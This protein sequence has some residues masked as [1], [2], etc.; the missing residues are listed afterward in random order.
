[1]SSITIHNE[2]ITSNNDLRLISN[3]GN[4]YFD[5]YLFPKTGDI[6]D[7][8]KISSNNELAWDKS[9]ITINENYLHIGSN[10][11][12][13]HDF[14][15]GHQNTSLI[16][17]DFDNGTLSINTT[18]FIMNS[19]STVQLYSDQTILLSSTNDQ[20]V[21]HAN[22]TSINGIEIANTSGGVLLEA[23]TN[24]ITG[25]LQISDKLLQS[26]HI[27]I[28]TNTNIYS[29]T[30]RVDSGTISSLTDLNLNA[31]AGNNIKLGEVS[32]PNT[33]GSTGQIL[34]LTNSNT[35]DWS[36]NISRFTRTEIDTNTFT[37]EDN[38]EGI[39]GIIAA[40]SVNIFLPLSINYNN[41]NNNIK[42][43]TFVDERGDAS[44]NNIIIN[45]TGTDLI[46][47]NSTYT[48]NGNY[49]SINI[50]ADGKTGWYIV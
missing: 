48:L 42:K 46:I 39:F 8:L 1:M 15:I 30:L 13:S 25:P 37:I 9:G 26:S 50:Y 45:R 40:T 23:A 20:V 43:I 29:N 16:Y 5:G 2:T 19:G 33:L 41:N 38:S 11:T 32:F 14:I 34:S 10:I 28:D 35:L 3:N 31:S 22:N 36:S 44:T 18:D 49:N 7:T 24:I 47:G 12:G 17:G 6:N 21:I 27:I 4:I